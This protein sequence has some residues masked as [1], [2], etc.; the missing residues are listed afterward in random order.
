MKPTTVEILLL[1][2][3]AFPLLEANDPTDKDS[4][5]YYDYHSLRVSGMICAGILCFVGIAILISGKCKCKKKTSVQALVP[6]K[7]NLSDTEC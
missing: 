1:L 2:L 6:V 3:T 4:P 5:F 7:T